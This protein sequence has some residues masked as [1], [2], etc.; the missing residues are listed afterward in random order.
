MKKLITFLLFMTTISLTSFTKDDNEENIDSDEDNVELEFRK[1]E[2]VPAHGPHRAPIYMDIEAYYNHAKHILEVCY[3]GENTGE[4]FLYL[5]DA[6]VDYSPEL[7][8]SFQLT[9]PGLYKILIIDGSWIA[10]GI[11]KY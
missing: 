11:I 6:I 2:H 3:Y 9:I 10:T 1:K 8:T 5:N 7:N 4:V